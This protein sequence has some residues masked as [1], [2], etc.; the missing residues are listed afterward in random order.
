MALLASRRRPS[1]PRDASH[2]PSRGRHPRRV[3]G[4]GHPQRDLGL[5]RHPGPAR[6]VRAAGHRLPALRPEPPRRGL[7]GADLGP[8][9]RVHGQPRRRAGG[10]PGPADVDSLRAGGG[11]RGADLLGLD[12]D[13]QHQPRAA[14]PARPRPLLPRLPH[15]PHHRVAGRAALEHRARPRHH[16]GPAGLA[17]LGDRATSCR[18]SSWWP[19]CSASRGRGRAP[20]STASSRRRPTT[21]SPTPAPRSSP[22]SRSA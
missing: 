10:R 15:R 19:R 7:A 18:P 21:R 6:P 17:R 9:S 11:P 1:Q 14:A 12:G 5:E 20:G 4:H 8:R 2:R 16:G 3:A 22:R 13:A